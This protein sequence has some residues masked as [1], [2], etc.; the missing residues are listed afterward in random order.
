MS[1]IDEL[2]A[3][4][5]T[6]VHNYVCPDTDC[7][8]NECICYGTGEEVPESWQCPRCATWWPVK[9]VN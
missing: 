4:S 6:I 8:G 1:R 5:C 2:Y 3:A 7:D 9:M